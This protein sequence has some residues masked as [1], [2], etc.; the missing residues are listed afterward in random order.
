[1]KSK[2]ILNVKSLSIERDFNIQLTLW[3]KVYL[4]FPSPKCFLMEK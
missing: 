1:M 3:V 2:E 4:G